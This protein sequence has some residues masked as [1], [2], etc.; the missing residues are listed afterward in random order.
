[1]IWNRP[2]KDLIARLLAPSGL[3]DLPWQ[4]AIVGSAHDGTF[5]AIWTDLGD[6]LQVSDRDTLANYAPP[7][8]RAGLCPISVGFR[9]NANGPARVLDQRQAGTPVR[10]PLAL[11]SSQARGLF[12]WGLFARG[13]NAGRVTRNGLEVSP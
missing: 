3:R 11:I 1:M 6:N 5:A 10:R 12:A 4:M 2:L 8:M 7:M 13:Q 9:R